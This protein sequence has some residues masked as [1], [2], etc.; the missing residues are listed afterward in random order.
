[1]TAPVL[2]L[3]VLPPSPP[4]ETVEAALAF[5]GLAREAELWGD[6]VLQWVPTQEA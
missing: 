3:H 4:C 6:T 5:K 1:M 2:V